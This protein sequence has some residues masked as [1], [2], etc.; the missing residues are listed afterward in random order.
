M[1][2]EGVHLTSYRN[3]A[4]LRCTLGPELNILV[5]PNA[6]GKT[7]LLEAIYLLATT[8]SMR[9]SRDQEL[10]R[11]D[12]ER[13]TVT[14]QVRRTRRNDINLEV[15]IGRGELKSM[16]INGARQPRVMDFVGQFNAV[17]FSSQDVEVVRGEPALRRRFLDLEI[18]QV[19]PSYC[20]A[21]AYY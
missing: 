2:L 4:D 16:R 21:L 20:H 3:Y 9:G 19:S 1:L 17:V 11:W 10:I 13:A 12:A 6:Q 14:G 5:G 7:N 18:S 15:T 8:K